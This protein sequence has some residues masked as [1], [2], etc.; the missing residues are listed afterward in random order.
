MGLEVGQ[1]RLWGL[2]IHFLD[3]N[4]LLCQLHPELFEG[5][6]STCP[7]IKGVK[8]VSVGDRNIEQEPNY[9]LGAL[10]MYVIVPS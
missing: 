8:D 10:Q 7:D 5:H 6:R 3:S 1:G 4:Q 9:V 2:P